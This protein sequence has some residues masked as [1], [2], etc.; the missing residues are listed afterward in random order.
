M[1]RGRGSKYEISEYV[2]PTGPLTN[3]AY[4]AEEIISPATVSMKF[5]FNVQFVTTVAVM[6]ESL[7]RTLDSTCTKKNFKKPIF[8]FV[9]Y[10]EVRNA[11]PSEE[12]SIV[13]NPHSR[14]SIPT[15]CAKTS[16]WQNY[17]T[18]H[19]ISE[20]YFALSFQSVLL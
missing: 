3:G 14:R 8:F 10:K 16:T 12:S 5:T 11:L 17:N 20:A 9:S 18:V 4:K 13:G 6:I 19:Y 1:P 15:L 2:R 7:H